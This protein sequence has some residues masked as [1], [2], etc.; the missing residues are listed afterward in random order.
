MKKKERESSKGC[1]DLFLP[2]TVS[3]TSTSKNSVN[4]LN[5]VVNANSSELNSRNLNNMSLRSQVQLRSC[6]I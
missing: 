1:K 5:I 3:V 6:Y 2:N 4:G